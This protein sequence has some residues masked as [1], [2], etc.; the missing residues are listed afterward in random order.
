GAEKNIETYKQVADKI[1]ST[2]KTISAILQKKQYPTV[3]H[4]ID[5]CSR[6]GFSANWLFLG[7]GSERMSEQATLDEIIREIRKL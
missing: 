3:Q 1:K 4:G 5:L 6:F 7:Q 2:D